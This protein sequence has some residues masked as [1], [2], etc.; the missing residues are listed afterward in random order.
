MSDLEAVDVLAELTRV[1]EMLDEIALDVPV[2]GTPTE[3]YMVVE[4]LAELAKT[5]GI[6]KAKVSKALF[7]D[8][9]RGDHPLDDG[10]VLHVGYTASRTGWDKEALRSEL[11]RKALGVT[12]DGEIT[13]TPVEVAD[14]LWSVADVAVGRTKVLRALLDGD[15]DEY[16]KEEWKPNMERRPA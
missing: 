11:T 2:A 14:R 5:A 8:L 13:A 4:A 9:G 16:C 7:E 1:R 3:R 12:A 6:G 10:D 15:L